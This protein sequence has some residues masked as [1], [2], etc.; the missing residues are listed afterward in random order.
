MGD[1]SQ[2]KG[3]QAFAHILDQENGSINPNTGSLRFVKPLVDLRGVRETVDL[4]LSLSY[5]AGNLGTFGLPFN[6][7]LD[8]PY[9]IPETS[10]T[11]KGRTY[12][13]DFSWADTSDYLSGLKYVNNHG[14]KFEKV[15]PAQPLPSGQ[16][17]FHGYKLQHGD[18][19]CDYFDEQGKPV[20]HVDIFG[21]YLHYSYATG[22]DSNVLSKDLSLGFILDSWQQ[23]ISFDYEPQQAIHITLPD[24][25]RV[26]V[27]FS[28][29]GV[30]TIC[31]LAGYTTSI[32]YVSFGSSGPLISQ[33]TYPTG[34]VSRFDYIGIAYLDANGGDQK[35][36]AV[37][38]HRRCEGDSKVLMHMNYRYGT[39]SGN[40][41]TGASRACR[42]GGSTD[43]LIDGS[44]QHPEYQYDV[45]QT[46]YDENGEALSATCTWFNYLH[47]PIKEQR[48]FVD[49][50][51]E[52]PHA[53][54][55]EFTYEIS[56]DAHARSTNYMNPVAVEQQRI[57]DARSET[58]R[59]LSRTIFAYNE[60]GNATSIQEGIIGTDS[61]HI[62]QKTT[63]N[64]YVTTK[65]N[66]HVQQLVKQTVQDE[67][68]GAEYVTE[69]TLSDDEKTV[70][71][72]SVSFKSGT[73]SGSQLQPWK[74]QLFTYDREG[75]ILS[76]TT[77][78]SPTAK[79]P[80]DSVSSTTTS[81][82]YNFE[83]GILTERSID[84]LNNATI[85]QRD[86]RKI[87]GPIVQKCLPLG[88]LEN[89][90]YDKI[91]RIT[92]RTDALG[93]STVIVYSVGFGAN[94][95]TVYSPIRYIK[96]TKRD[97]LGREVEVA[98][99]GDPTNETKAEITRVI[100]RT[101]YDCLSRIIQYTDIH[102]LVTTHTYDAL[103]RPLRTKDPQGNIVDRQYNDIE[104][105]VQRK[106]NGYLRSM[107][108]LDG[109]GQVISQTTHPDSDDSSDASVLV[110]AFEYDG[111]IRV[112]K[113]SLSKSSVTAT[114]LI[115][116]TT[117]K[118]DPN[119]HTTTQITVGFADGA[120]D[121]VTRQFTLD[122]FG[123][124]YT[125][126]KET[127]YSG[128]RTFLHKGPVSLYNKTNKLAILRNQLKQEEI[129]SYNENGCLVGKKR[130]DGTIVGYTLDAIGQTTRIV[131]PK[132][133]TNVT[134]LPDGRTSRIQEN[135][136]TI[137]YKYSRDGS[138]TTISFG[139][140]RTQ[141]YTLDRTSRVVK[142]IDVFGVARETTFDRFGRVT[143]RSCQGDVVSYTYGTVNHTYGQ[144]TQANMSGQHI[145]T[146][147][148][149]YS[150]YD[151]VSR[152]AVQDAHSNTLVDT[153][154]S[155]NSRGQ[156]QTLKSTSTAS[157][158]LNVERVFQYDGLG[159]VVQ[160][161]IVSDTSSVAKYAYDGNWNIVSAER[162]GQVRTMAYNA[163][164]QRADP[165]FTYDGNG[166]LVSDDTGCRYSFDD[167]D[168][169]LSV[170]MTSNKTSKFAYR[171]DKALSEYHGPSQGVK[172]YHSE[173]EKKVN[174]MEI[175]SHGDAQ[176]V[177]NQYSLFSGGENII[178]SYNKATAPTYF[179]DQ[180]GS[181]TLLFGPGG[182]T[183]LTYD[184]YGSNKEASPLSS[185][186]SSFGFN[187]E[188]SDPASGLVYLRSRYYNPRHMAFVSMDSYHKENRYAFCQ[189]D[190]VNYI[191]PSGHS[192][193]SAVAWIL[194]LA[195]GVVAGVLTAG[196][197]D[198]AFVAMGASA[199]TASIAA[200]T[201]GGAVGNL[202]AGGV[203]AVVSGSS[204]DGSQA[205]R[206]LA[207][208]AVGGLLG[209]GVGVAASKLGASTLGAT[210][211]GGAV[212]GAAQGSMAFALSQ[213]PVD[214]WQ[215]L[216]SAATGAVMGSVAS[217][218]PARNARNAAAREMNQIRGQL[219]RYQP[220]REDPA[221]RVRLAQQ[222]GELH[223]LLQA[224]GYEPP[225]LQPDPQLIVIEEEAPPR[226]NWWDWDSVA[227]P[228]AMLDRCSSR[229][230]RRL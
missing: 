68:S 206:D 7:G 112:I 130:F 229:L 76:S 60:Y 216:L 147:I 103:N 127:K 35:L 158:K 46:S 74:Q 100:S 145:Y 87:S 31:D 8:L 176:P 193:V 11:V 208:G 1:A 99:N 45:F 152:V 62:K 98:D 21:N 168:C 167:Q 30:D 53:Y 57:V 20:E 50:K 172:L 132:S 196:L 94:T 181:T 15:S 224:N 151:R 116:E 128:G 32:E 86:M 179:L 114:S 9:V 47:L 85:Y 135:S 43:A 174:A 211:A 49:S 125:Y 69:N 55:A 36:A 13:I 202:A 75:R 218:W 64:Q 205:W 52:F 164:D 201:V 188:F 227:N 44:S 66:I 82:T 120:Q 107:T 185:L 134:Y 16:P 223:E 59:P 89:F 197:A 95:Q 144:L 41:F 141:A 212:G 191:D 161:S 139:D 65:R 63:T 184:T 222:V 153:K 90:E 14:M 54:Q 123:N 42:M 111:H 219:R 119:S 137:D 187:Q 166:R 155:F 221:L 129:C 79:V 109:R 228:D 105:K 210:I 163:I 124:V 28:G 204:Y 203:S 34:L 133:T 178:A 117:R 183:T 194:G 38:D 182:S 199:A 214:A 159:Q 81:T 104:Q 80:D 220:G 138:L 88:Q 154:Y 77:A 160:D 22:K 215:I 61:K 195:A 92:K 48:R 170:E 225:L 209:T 150:G 5:S 12:A 207:T 192:Q 110:R 173:T 198:I 67:I 121:V 72:V 190:P 122:L 27:L 177:T 115:N 106:L 146:S 165:G 180:L 171:A 40:T 91:G 39:I 101:K 156:I 83:K 118:Y 175:L 51:G 58:Y 143:N 37:M 189:G 142:E 4:K 19:S 230:L 73:S 56:E 6:W 97:A 96:R 162:R 18:G 84:A 169:L 126:T 3:S 26:S 113:E 186:H 136:D 10:L 140:G 213:E 148:I 17:G 157:P 24:T 149:T 93:S 226:A 29:V 108:L 23:T 78:W 102:E 33:I 70:N 217:R 71:V 200:G 2:Y 25:N 131:H